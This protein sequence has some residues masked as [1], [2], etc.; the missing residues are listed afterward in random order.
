[1]TNRA[2]TL[3]RDGAPIAKGVGEVEGYMALWAHTAYAVQ[4][5][6]E[7]DHGMYWPVGRSFSATYA[8][9]FDDTPKKLI[10]IDDRPN[11]VFVLLLWIFGSAGSQQEFHIARSLD[12]PKRDRLKSFVQAYLRLDTL[13]AALKELSVDYMKAIQDPDASR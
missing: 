1:M 5:D 4:F 8:L 6:M 3:S 10:T 9:A 12:N 11:D 2:W 7:L 13:D